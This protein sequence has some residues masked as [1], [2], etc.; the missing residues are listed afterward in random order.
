MSITSEG[1]AGGK[2]GVSTGDKSRGAGGAWY[3]DGETR[4]FS[5]KFE[6]RLD[7]DSFDALFVAFA[8][9]RCFLLAR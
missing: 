8:F 9:I 4:C 5:K 2:W 6:M 7:L 1:P 3:D